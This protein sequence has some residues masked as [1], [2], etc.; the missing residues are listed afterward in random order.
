M[1]NHD[2]HRRD[3]EDRTEHGSRYEGDDNSRCCSRAHRWWKDFKHRVLRRT[4][5]LTIKYHPMKPA[6]DK[7][8]PPVDDDS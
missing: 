2:N 4:G 7:V 8:L 1:S 6:G 5:K 3:E